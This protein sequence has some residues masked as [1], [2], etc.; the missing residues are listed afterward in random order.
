MDLPLDRYT[1]TARL[2][3]VWI[4]F[5]PVALVAGVLFGRESV[6][7]GLAIWLGTAVV[8][9]VLFSQLGRDRGRK[10]EPRLFARW[11]GPPTTVY[12]RH[13]GSP[14]NPLTHERVIR[15]LAAT[16]PGLRWPTPDDEAA[17]AGAADK[18]YESA[19]LFLREHTRDTERFQLVFAENVS[20][21]FR[22]NLWAMKPTGVV[23]SATCALILAAKIARDVGE[24]SPCASSWI[25][26]AASVVLLVTWFLRIREPWVHEAANAYAERLLGAVEVL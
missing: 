4:V 7:T 19:S 1:I 15:K 20:Y 22:R 3:P 6:E 23:V 16:I 26:L 21:G 8:L 2:A 13:R 5:L 17:D 9:T 24:R 11:G 25:A 12:L 18:V 14:L 10:I